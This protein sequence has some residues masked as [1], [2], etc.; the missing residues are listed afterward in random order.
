MAVRSKRLGAGLQNAGASASIYTVPTGYRTI[1]KGVSAYN[2]AAAVNRFR[3]ELYEGGTFTS[4]L[5]IALGANGGLDEAKTLDLFQVLN[6]G[7][8]LRV[9]AGSTSI[10]YWVSGAELLL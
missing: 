1:V 7:D 10:Y 2:Q 9:G 5:I 3:L 4:Y 6:A 8:E